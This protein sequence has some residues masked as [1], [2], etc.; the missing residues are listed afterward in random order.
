MKMGTINFNL[1]ANM[2]SPSIWTGSVYL[3]NSNYIVLYDGSNGGV[4]AG[5]NFS[6][7]NQSNVIG[8]TLTGYG[9]FKN[10][11][12]STG[13]YTIDYIADG[14]NLSAVTAYSYINGRNALGLQQWALSG[15]D[16]FNGSSYD[17]YIIGYGGNDL[18]N[19]NDGN[20]SIF[21]GDG[22]DTL[23]GGDGNNTIDGGAGN[24]L[25]TLKKYFF[26]YDIKYSGGVFTLSNNGLINKITN[27][28]TFRFLNYGDSYTDISSDELK[29]IASDVTPPV[30]ISLNAADR[31]NLS[32]EKFVISMAATDTA[33]GV[34]SANIYLD[35]KISYAY[36][37]NGDF[38]DSDTLYFSGDLVTRPDPVLDS[39]GSW[40]DGTAQ[41]DFWLSPSNRN[42]EYKIVKIEIDD[43]NGNKR[44]Y[45]SSELKTIGINTTFT[46]Y[47]SEIPNSLPS[48][49]LTITGTLNSGRLLTSS[50]SISD[51]DGIPT[52]GSNSIKYQW[53]SKAVS[54]SDWSNIASASSSFYLLKNSEIQKN[55]RLKASYTDNY[56][57]TET[58]YSDAT[59][60]VTHL[61]SSPSGRV[62]IS[63]NA[64]KN[65]T[66]T[67]QNSLSDSDGIPFAGSSGAIAYTWSADGTRIDGANSASLLLT[68]SVIGKKITVTATYTDL[69]GTVETVT[70][71]ATSAVLNVNDAPTGLVTISGAAT[72]RE[73]LTAS[74]T[75]ADLDGL[76]TI[77]YQWNA[78]GIA[79]K[80]ATSDSFA[81]TQAVVGKVISVTA[82]YTDAFGAKESAKSAG[83][84]KIANVNDLPTGS[85]VIKGTVAKGQT[86]TATNTIADADGLGT[87]SYQWQSSSDGSTWTAISGATKSSYK[88]VNSD[89]SKTIR[90]KISYTDKLGTPESVLTDSY[91]VANVNDK[92]VGVPTIIGKLFEGET[93]TANATKITDGDGLGT[94]SYLWQTSSNK[95][96]WTDAGTSATYQLGKASAGQF[97]QLTVSYT[98]KN[99]TAEVVKSAVSSKIVSKA[100]TIAGT[101]DADTLVG[102]SGNDT[103]TGAGGTDSLTGGAGKDT[104][105]FKAILDSSVLAPDQITDFSSGD[106]IDLKAIDANTARASDQAFTIS[107]SGAA[108]NSVWW[109]SG[110][111][112]LFGDNNGN[113]IADFAIKVSL[114]GS[115]Q[116]QAADIVL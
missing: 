81:L 83:T 47:G 56:G 80:D 38:S 58:I 102:M 54:D 46:F 72:Q 90:L 8:G 52:T 31:V 107:S 44:T 106:K 88:L 108:A 82:S 111:N 92:P 33:A 17:D 43:N 66:L 53:Q 100:A 57:T 98:D 64:K 24:D 29:S 103:I 55:I 115:T 40:Q 96:A 25:V 32:A 26:F 23:D 19:G 21:G 99:G 48:G 9:N 79:I 10:F 93:L 4:Y 50:N 3:A 45:L 95:T 110:S 42:G 114:V 62:L 85:I 37:E 97:V 69:L 112:T 87:L 70:S 67:V 27:V 71:S 20:D 76:G 49:N 109:D 22:N 16:T 1:A 73:I 15:S 2:N 59:D 11:N 91:T 30:L 63:G 68:Q 89:V 51:A 86:L 104:F 75:L 101:S 39:N 105:V 6:Y 13:T 61:N 65:S 12:S 28:E 34:Q 41:E 74:N 116:L 113:T 78:D 7:G 60:I 84:T 36:S 5:Y 18:I 94:F 14:F 77:S 35:K